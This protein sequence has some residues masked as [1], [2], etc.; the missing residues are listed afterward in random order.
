M[1]HPDG[2][3][4]GGEPCVVCGNPIPKNGHWKHKDRHACGSRCNR[5]LARHFLK[6]LRSG[7]LEQPEP[8]AS[9][10]TRPRPA[11]FGENPSNQNCPY[12]FDG[13]T[14]LDGDSVERFGSTTTYSVERGRDGKPRF[15][16]RHAQSGATSVHPANE[17]GG[18]RRVDL[19]RT[20]PSGR[21]LEVGESFEH[22]GRTFRWTREIIRDVT[23]DGKPYEWEAPICVPADAPSLI[24]VWT[25][26]YEDR[27]KALQAVTSTLAR[28]VRRL[29]VSAEGSERFS[30]AEVF[31]RDGW[32]CG[33]CHEPIAPDVRWPDRMSASLDHIISLAAG[34]KHTRDNC[35]AAHWICNVR[36]GARQELMAPHGGG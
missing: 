29:R 21:R 12:D 25:R 10:R 22:H 35:Q 11:H 3:A 9:P 34:G 17:A 24:P 2:R 5:L 13:F 4:V 8:M 16:A 6:H 31:E 36:K 32:I 20:D 28:H 19:L 18:Y 15:V 27:S 23:D 7:D 1:L 30:A 33:L 26:A 14:P